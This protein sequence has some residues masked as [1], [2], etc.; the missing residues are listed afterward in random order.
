MVGNGTENH[1]RGRTNSRLKKKT[2]KNRQLLWDGITI[3]TVMGTD[4]IERVGGR[5]INRSRDDRP[6]DD[7]YIKSANA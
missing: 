5:W 1:F 3:L 7:S 4:S 6:T 2:K